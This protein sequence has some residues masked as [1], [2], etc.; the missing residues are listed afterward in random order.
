[1]KNTYFQVKKGTFTKKP[2]FRK[3]KANNQ[4]MIICVIWLRYL[5]KNG[6]LN[7]GASKWMFKLC[8]RKREDIANI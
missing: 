8:K 2:T 6:L 4:R 7:G 3:S 5:T 1:M